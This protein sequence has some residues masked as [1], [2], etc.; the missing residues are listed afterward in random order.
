MFKALILILL[1][2]FFTPVDAYFANKP[3]SQGII[4]EIFSLTNQEKNISS[5]HNLIFKN[6]KQ[7]QTAAINVRASRQADKIAHVVFSQSSLYE[8]LIQSLHLTSTPDELKSA[9]KLLKLPLV[10]KMIKLETKDIVEDIE[11]TKVIYKK[12]LKR[13]KPSQRREKLIRNWVEKSAHAESVINIQILIELM[14]AS[15]IYPELKLYISDIKEY[16]NTKTAQQKELLYLKYIY[17]YRDASDYELER[18]LNIMTSKTGH[19][20]TGTLMNAYVVSIQQLGL[21]FFAHIDRSYTPRDNLSNDN[22]ELHVT[23]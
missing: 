10:Q 2:L 13:V 5:I 8:S 21:D 12:Y 19:W 17:I 23:H 16:Q 18:Y 14:V 6:I 9:K 11:K 1:T 20:L 7:S 15:A 4:E 22:H 3:P